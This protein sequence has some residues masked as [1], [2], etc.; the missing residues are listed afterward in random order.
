MPLRFTLL[1][2][3]LTLSACSTSLQSSKVTS[4]HPIV[5]KGSR[6]VATC[7]AAERRCYYWD[8]GSRRIADVSKGE[9]QNRADR[10][11][12][13]LL[14]ALETQASGYSLYNSLH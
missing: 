5:V 10:V 1:T 6:T 13:A 2:F 9:I 7:Y 4:I 3:A 14:K 11:Y 12:Q 8:N